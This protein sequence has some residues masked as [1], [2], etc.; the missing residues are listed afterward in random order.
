MSFIMEKPGYFF[1][2][3]AN[4]LWYLF[5]H[6]R[7]YYTNFHN[8]L[9]LAF[10]IPAYFFATLGLPWAS[11][12]QRRLRVLLLST[13][14]C[15]AL[16]TSVTFT[17]WDGRFLIPLLYVVFLYAAIGLWRVLDHYFRRSESGA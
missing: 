5:S 17:D 9:S 16:I 3:L 15:Q 1:E 14:V 8:A 7:P 12:D 4:K 13:L 2:L 11:P 10:L 6:I